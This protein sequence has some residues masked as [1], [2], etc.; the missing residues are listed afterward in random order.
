MIG[1]IGITVIVAD[2]Q[3]GV[4][5]IGASLARRFPDGALV[6]VIPKIIKQ[7]KIVQ[8]E[9]IPDTFILINDIF[10]V[11]NRGRLANPCGGNGLRSDGR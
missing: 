9:A 10:D 7:I 1:R 3:N 5:E 2:D 6:L 8:V 11:G 4:A